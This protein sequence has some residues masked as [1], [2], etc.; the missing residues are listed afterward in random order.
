VPLP[1][2]FKKP[3]HA[4]VAIATP[5]WE[6]FLKSFG[7][8][9]FRVQKNWMDIRAIKAKTDLINP[10]GNEPGRQSPTS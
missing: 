4:G 8:G 6:G 2:L 5:A 9:T 3:S 10:S 7:N 1:K